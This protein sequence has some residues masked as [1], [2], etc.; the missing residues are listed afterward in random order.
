MFINKSIRVTGCITQEKYIKG[1]SLTDIERILG[2]HAGRLNEG[3]VVA[4]LQQIPAKDQFQLLGYT[5]VAEHRF[6]TSALKG[7]D[8]DELKETVRQN[9]FSLY[10]VNRLIKV[11]PNIRHQ[12]LMKDDDQYPPGSGVP[13]WKLT[14]PVY[15]I[16]VAIVKPGERYF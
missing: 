12:Q 10:G 4:A 13:Q 15:A 7:L 6:N 2:F 9:T 3:M 11:M 1:R 16:V 8:S 14:S 5:Q